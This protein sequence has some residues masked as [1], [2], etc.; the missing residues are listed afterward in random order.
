MFIYCEIELYV[1][2][3]KKSW[4]FGTFLLPLVLL[5]NMSL[6]LTALLNAEAL[7][8]PYMYFVKKKK[9]SLMCISKRCELTWFLCWSVFFVLFYLHCKTNFLTQYFIFS[10]KQTVCCLNHTCKSVTF[11][12]ISPFWQWNRIA[13]IFFFVKTCFI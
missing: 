3:L 4:A 10:C 6:V 13:W 7:G 9:K 11:W 2:N 12:Q 1:V 5:S 8:L